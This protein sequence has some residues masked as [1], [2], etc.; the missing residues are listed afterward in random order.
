MPKMSR[1]PLMGLVK[2]DISR[3]YYAVDVATAINGFTRTRYESDLLWSKLG[4]EA[5]GMTSSTRKVRRYSK[6]LWQV[7]ENAATRTASE[8]TAQGVANCIYGLYQ[9]KQTSLSRASRSSR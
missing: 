1:M 8:L 2:W 4:K 5:T 9:A 3:S 6:T 7:L